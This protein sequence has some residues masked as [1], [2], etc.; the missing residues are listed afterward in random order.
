MPFEQKMLHLA[1]ANFHARTHEMVL[2]VSRLCPQN[3][4]ETDRGHLLWRVLIRQEEAKNLSLE[5][6]R[7]TFSHLNSEIAS[8][9][10]AYNWH[11]K[12]MNIWSNGSKRSNWFWRNCFLSV[13]YAEDRKADPNLKDKPFILSM[14]NAS[15]HVSEKTQIFLA[16]ARLRA[17][18]ITP[19]CPSLNLAEKLLLYLQLF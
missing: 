5:P 10:W 13:R 18:T 6:T 1:S 2:W 19:R 8:S 15:V 3:A 4:A 11:F 9:K 14:D 16:R 17:I 7:D 12:R